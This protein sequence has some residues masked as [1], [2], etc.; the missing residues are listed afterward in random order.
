MA[1]EKFREDEYVIWACIECEHYHYWHKNDSGRDGLRCEKCDGYI[2]VVGFTNQ[3]PRPLHKSP[4]TLTVDLDCSDA[5]K[6]LKS[7]QREA[8][9]ATAAL[10]EFEEQKRITNMEIFDGEA[11]CPKCGSDEVKREQMISSGSIVN[12]KT[13]CKDCGWSE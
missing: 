9:K 12:E 3:K 8:R 1:D 11:E 7:I 13:E 2:S 4:G 5:I 6:G 10:K